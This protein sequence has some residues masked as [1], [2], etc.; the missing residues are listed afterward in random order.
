MWEPQLAAMSAGGWHVVAPHCRGFDSAGTGLDDADPMLLGRDPFTIDD[1]AGDIIDLLDAL[2]V[3]EAVIGGLSMGGCVAFALMRLAAR[4]VRA[5][6]LADTKPEADTAEGVEGRKRMVKLAQE[7]GAVAVVDQLMPKLVGSTTRRDRADVVDRVRS[8]GASRSAA[9]LIAAT[10]AMMMR[11]DSTALLPTIRVPTL[12]L[13]GD[14]DQITP[15]A[16]AENMGK[17]I[18]GSELSVIHGAGHL[19]NLENPHAFNEALARFLE[20]RV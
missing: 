6:V 11:P 9:A 5:L 15:P 17:A 13:V 2:R 16:V 10:T 7:Q 14:E 4:Y 12:I 8:I 18:A 1:F 20:Y 19:S 3:H